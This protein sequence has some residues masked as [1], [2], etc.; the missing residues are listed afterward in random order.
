MRTGTGETAIRQE[1]KPSNMLA[2]SKGKNKSGIKKALTILKAINAQRPSVKRLAALVSGSKPGKEAN[3]RPSLIPGGSNAEPRARA[4]DPAGTRSSSVGARSRS[5]HAEILHELDALRVKKQCVSRAQ[6]RIVATKNQNL[7]SY[8]LSVVNLHWHFQI[9]VLEHLRH[10]A[11]I[12]L[13]SF[14]LPRS[15]KL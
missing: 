4:A 11:C 12:G 13:Y 3:Q 1:Q 2:I 10:T 8:M 7:N 9:Q 5:K 15:P 6:C 14:T